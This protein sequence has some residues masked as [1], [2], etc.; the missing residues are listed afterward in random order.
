MDKLITDFN[1]L[2]PEFAASQ[3]SGSTDIIEP[4]NDG[5]PGTFQ[6]LTVQI[7]PTAIAWEFSR[8]CLEATKSFHDLACPSASAVN[9]CH[10]V[11][12]KECDGMLCTQD[13]AGLITFHVFELKSGF[14]KESITKAKDQI[15]GSYLKMIHLLA[16]LQTFDLSRIRMT[17]YIAAYE[18][19]VE[20]L[21]AIKDD[22]RAGYFC[23]QLNAK[24]R[25]DMPASK[26]EKYW[27]PLSCGDIAINFIKV[28]SGAASHS[29]TI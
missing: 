19:S 2:Y 15:V 20:T 23:I 7:P 18:P 26:C 4:E 3:F 5:K 22:A 11:M 24:G 17:G 13:A 10:V 25:Y 21:T 12:K 27:H 29:V 14:T 1:K 9:H 16:P 8:P 6:H 28:P